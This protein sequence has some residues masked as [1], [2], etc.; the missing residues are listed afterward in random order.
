MSE[1]IMEFETQEQLDKCLAEWQE[2]LF[3]TDW[4]IKVRFAE[5]EELKDENEI[6]L[7]GQNEFQIV[8][9][10]AVISLEKLND[11]SRSRIVKICHEQ[12]LIHELLHCKYNWIEPPYTAEGK[13]FDTLEHSLIEQMAKSLFMAKYN[14]PF[15]W[16]KNF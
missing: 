8:N 2:R 5:P 4:T 14:L 12:I 11:D 6:R 7:S 15:S 3:L 9:K 13:Y 1:P 10:C 16:F